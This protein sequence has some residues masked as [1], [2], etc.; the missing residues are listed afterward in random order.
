MLHIMVFLNYL[1]S[2]GNEAALQK[3]GWAMGIYKGAFN[4]CVMEASQENSDVAEE[5]Y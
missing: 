3:I 1:G 2:Y 4:D 5:V